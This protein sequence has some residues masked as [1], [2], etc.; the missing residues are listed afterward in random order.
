MPALVCGTVGALLMMV[1]WQFGIL[2]GFI[3]HN[4]SFSCWCSAV[5][6]PVGALTIMFWRPKGLM[7]VDR[8]CINQFDVRMKAE[9]I[10][11][12]G[13]VLSSSKS[14]LVMFD[15]SYAERLWCVF[16]LS[17][18]LKAQQGRVGDKLPNVQI[19]PLLLGLVAGSVVVCVLALGVFAVFNPFDNVIVMWSMLL[20]FVLAEG[21]F[22]VHA[23]RRYF[24]SLEHTLQQLRDFQ[25]QNAFC[26][27][28]SVNHINPANGQPV[29]VCDREIVRQCVTSWFGAE[30]KFNESVRSLLPQAL[31]QQLG[32][33]A[34]PY[35][36]ILGSTAPIWWPFIDY[37]A[38][39]Q[40]SEEVS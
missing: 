30:D 8:M 7:F 6:L 22:V 4:L 33:D 32:A 38:T 15:E 23:F 19:K 36:W 5:G 3:K 34:F 21:I 16:E 25:L 37:L 27:C 12:I 13:A 24:R 18:F 31:M 9:G 14:F 20:L 1:V 11:N 28:C 40:A 29:P 10:L 17:A 39:Y 35:K 2:P 26:W